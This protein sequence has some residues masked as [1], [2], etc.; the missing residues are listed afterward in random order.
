MRA[1]FAKYLL[2]GYAT[3][4]WI[5]RKIELDLEEKIKE[6]PEPLNKYLDKFFYR[7]ISN[8]AAKKSYSVLYE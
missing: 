7:P 4:C 3:K 6:N 1:F 2:G 8:I 5:F